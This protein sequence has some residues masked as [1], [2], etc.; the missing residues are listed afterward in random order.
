VGIYA[1]PS[2]D[3]K[4]KLGYAQN[5]S[6]VPVQEDVVSRESCSGGWYAVAGGGYICNNSGTLNPEHP[7]VKFA[8]KQPDWEGVLPYPYAR[9][10][11]NGTPLYKSV[12]SKQQME[13][14]EPHLSESKSKAK[15]GG[16]KSERNAA[17]SGADEKVNA[18]SAASPFI[19]VGPHDAGADRATRAVSLALDAGAEAGGLEAEPEEPWWKR[20]DAKDSL[21]EVT[22]EQLSQDADDVLARRLVTGF[23]VAVDKTFNWNGRS[24]YRTTKRLVAPADRFWQTGASE[25]HGVELGKEFHLPVAWGYGGRKNITLYKIDEEKKTVAIDKS[26]A[27]FEPIQLKQREIELRGHRY[28][29]TA[30]GSWVRADHVRITRPGN[31]PEELGDGERWI[32]VNLAEQTL[33]AYD[34]S[35]PVYATLVSSG[36]RS[37]EKAKD[38][39]TPVGHWRIREKHVTTTMDGN[40]SAAGDLPYSIED[41]PYAMYFHRAYAVHGAFWHRNYGVQMSHGCVNLAPLDAKFLFRFTEPPLPEGWHGV[42]ATDER[43]GSFVVVHE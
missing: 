23:Y 22:L 31:P 30:D 41:V 12:P 9:N 32:D 20:E 40:G 14:Y 8:V 39:R 33:V 16:D 15:Q 37:R 13:Q 42:W 24:W 38:H 35:T 29:E 2:F 6:R 17:R 1:K 4:L 26:I 10:A 34:G 43:P 36:K 5:G 21:H 25:F 19:G 11:H 3:R 27:R 18:V 28:F 7:E